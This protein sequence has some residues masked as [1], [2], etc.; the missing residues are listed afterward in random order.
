MPNSGRHSLGKKKR[1]RKKEKKRKKKLQ[2][3]EKHV[4]WIL[5]CTRELLLQTH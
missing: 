5:L 3:R 4:E 2:F 1:I